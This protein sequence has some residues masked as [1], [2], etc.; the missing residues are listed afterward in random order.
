MP[1][2]AAKR[3]VWAEDEGGREAGVEAVPTVPGPPAYRVPSGCAGPTSTS[4]RKA[5]ETPRGFGAPRPA[6]GAP[7][8]GGARPSLIAPASPGALQVAEGWLNCA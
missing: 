4:V 8:P 6:H 7:R 2:G 1:A 5:A 3:G